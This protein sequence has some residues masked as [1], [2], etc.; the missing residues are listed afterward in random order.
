MNKILNLLRSERLSAFFDGLPYIALCALLSFV[1]WLSGGML[2]ILIAELLLCA[3]ILPFRKTP[4]MAIPLALF[5]QHGFFDTSVFFV[6]WA[7]GVLIATG[8]L[9]LASLIYLMVKNKLRPTLSIMTVGFFALI[10]SHFFGGVTEGFIGSSYWLFGMGTVLF[11]TAF[12]ILISSC[13]KSLASRYTAMLFAVFG[14]LI[15]AEYLANLPRIIK[16]GVS[17]FDGVIHKF[18]LGWGH[19]NDAA[20]L[21]LIS[22]P[23]IAYLI[24]K[25]KKPTL[26]CAM[27]LFV[28]AVLILTLSRSAILAYAILLVPIVLVA[29]LK[30]KNRKAVLINFGAFAGVLLVVFLSLLPTLKPIFVTLRERGLGDNGRYNIW[31]TAIANYKGGNWFF[32][33]GFNYATSVSHMGWDEFETYHNVP[34]QFLSDLGVLGLLSYLFFIG[35]ILTPAVRLI[36][37]KQSVAFCVASIVAILAQEIMGLFLPSFWQVFYFVPLF[38]ILTTINNKYEAYQRLQEPLEGATFIKRIELRGN[39]L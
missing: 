11:A 25:E 6:P 8:V 36:I 10:V 32:G 21:M 9:A 39:N 17:L 23:F 18:G 22:I 37:K 19:P 12:F 4:R 24:S 34:L 1:G 33:R 29:F 28:S 15:C 30:A 14:C 2:Y 7:L 20:R 38:F 26:Y 3:L 31:E 16:Q 27:F 35:A 13:E 5:A